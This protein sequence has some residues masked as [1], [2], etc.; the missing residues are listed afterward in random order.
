VVPRRRAIM[1]TPS[2]AASEALPPASHRF[3]SSGSGI[4]SAAAVWTGAAGLA[5]PLASSRSSRPW[6][7]TVTVTSTGV[8]G[9]SQSSR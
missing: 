7:E 3:Q 4:R 2:S 9:M 6:A 1:P 8:S 5:T